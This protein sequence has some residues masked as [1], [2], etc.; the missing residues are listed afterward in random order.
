MEDKKLLN[1]EGLEKVS[2]GVN[3][4]DVPNPLSIQ[5]KEE[6]LKIAEQLGAG[7]DMGSWKTM[8]GE[9]FMQW[10]RSVHEKE[11]QKL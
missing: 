4:T 7:K 8:S 2:G 5:T 3:F 1:N 11:Y 6:A 10:W 9:E